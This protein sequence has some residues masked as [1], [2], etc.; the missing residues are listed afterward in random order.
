[1]VH[2]RATAGHRTNAAR[3]IDDKRPMR[4]PPLSPSLFLIVDLRHR[5]KEMKS[6]QSISYV[7]GVAAEGEPV[8][9]E[10]LPQTAGCCPRCELS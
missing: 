1:M 10:E 5:D 4:A 7:P 2:Q 3:V 8:C 6:V 9:W